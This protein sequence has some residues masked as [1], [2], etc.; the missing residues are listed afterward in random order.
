MSGSSEIIKFSVGIFGS[1]KYLNFRASIDWFLFMG[2]I[3]SNIKMLSWMVF[4][5]V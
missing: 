3:G 4:F 5:M 1:G 2:S